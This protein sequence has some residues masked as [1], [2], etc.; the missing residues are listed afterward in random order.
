[1]TY[2]DGSPGDCQPECLDHLE[3]MAADIE[4]KDRL[5]A[6]FVKAGTK[7][8][9]WLTKG[10]KHSITC[11][12]HREDIEYCNC[13]VADLQH[14]MREYRMSTNPE[15]KPEEAVAISDTSEPCMMRRI[16]RPEERDIE[17][18]C[19]NHTVYLEDRRNFPVPEPCPFCRGT[20]DD[21][22]NSRG[23]FGVGINA[24]N[25]CV[26]CYNQK[27]PMF[28]CVLAVEVWNGFLRLT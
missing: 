21:Y 8:E 20:H 5:I 19:E 7:Q 6:C 26:S 3:E 22:V 13:G 17:C 27:C 15:S 10:L 2:L 12:Y 23:K 11:N 1:M 24:P 14:A 18:P 4:E 9:E 25:G 16:C 28:N